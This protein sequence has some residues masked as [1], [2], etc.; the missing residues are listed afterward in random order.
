ME[1][2]LNDIHLKL[3]DLKETKFSNLFL[4]GIA[5][6]QHHYLFNSKV[7]NISQ[8]NPNWYVPDN[9]DPF[10]DSLKIYNKILGD[11]INNQ[12]INVMLATGL[13]Q[14]PYDRVKFYYKLKKHELF[15]DFFGIS[16][17]KVQELMSRDFILH[18]KNK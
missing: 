1:L 17:E 6:I 3:F 7:L 18:F 12:N 4:N 15:F 5:H 11:Y 2:L 13:T 9:L 10:K 14:V 16:F 8:E